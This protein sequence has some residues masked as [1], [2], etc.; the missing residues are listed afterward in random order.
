MFEQCLANLVLGAFRRFGEGPTGRPHTES[1]ACCWLAGDQPWFPGFPL[2][3]QQ[4]I[5]FLSVGSLD[6]FGFGFEV[7][8]PNDPPNLQTDPNEGS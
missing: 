8:L 4:V 5:R 6:W 3:T 7:L 2:P 1:V